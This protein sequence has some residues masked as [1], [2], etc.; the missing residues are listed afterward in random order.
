MSARCRSCDA[1]VVWRT[2]DKDRSMPLDPIPSRKGNIQLLEGGRCRVLT[3]PELTEARER[4]IK[5]YLS[6]FVTCLHAD[7][8]RKAKR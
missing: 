1:V 3:G 5:L 7:E 2:T 4:G 6:H 8:H